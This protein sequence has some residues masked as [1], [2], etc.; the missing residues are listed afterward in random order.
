M[1]PDVDLMAERI[2]NVIKQ[3]IEVYTKLCDAFEKTISREKRTINRLL[4]SFELT[5]DRKF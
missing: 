2:Q 1:H 4:L 5:L 3:L